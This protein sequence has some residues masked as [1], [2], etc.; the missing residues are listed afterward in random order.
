MIVSG[1]SL[2]IILIDFSCR[3]VCIRCKV[4]LDTILNYLANLIR[5]QRTL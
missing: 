3:L 4:K 1:Q 2:F 5:E